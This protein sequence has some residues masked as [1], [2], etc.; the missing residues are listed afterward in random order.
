MTAKPVPG[1]SVQMSSAAPIPV[2]VGALPTP[3]F[4]TPLPS[5]GRCGGSGRSCRAPAARYTFLMNARTY[6]EP[7]TLWQL[8]R[9]ERRPSVAL[10]LT[11]SEGAPFLTSVSL[12]HTR[13]GGV[14]LGDQVH[15]PGQL[16][17]LLLFPR[18]VQRPVE[19]IGECLNVGVLLP[20]L[21][22]FFVLAQ[23]RLGHPLGRAKD[24]P[25]FLSHTTR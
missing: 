16:D 4:P 15:T 18:F 5:P 22:S 20:D 14:Q 24:L 13:P 3:C 1:T 17:F 11:A 25:V 10:R 9:E 8:T 19:Q 21:D 6:C 23:L 7:T 12:R 2:N